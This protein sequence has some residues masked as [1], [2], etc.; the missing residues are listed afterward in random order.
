MTHEGVL[1]L[2]WTAVG[3]AFVHTIIG[4]DHSLP[5]VVLA[6]A[7][8]WSMR[9]LMGVVAL[10]GA[11]HVIGSIV[12]GAVG[13]SI[14]VALDKL[15][16]IQTARGDVAAWLL[17]GF[18]LAYFAWGVAR[19]LRG[20]KHS[21]W[22]GH[23]DGLEHDHN[24]DHHREHLHAH[25][26]TTHKV[27]RRLITTWTLFIIFAFGPCEALIPLLMAPAW[28]HSW[29]LVVAVALVFGVVTIGTMMGVVALAY[30]G[31]NSRIFAR[32]ELE[33]W[34]DAL[35]GLTIA[36]SGAAIMVLGI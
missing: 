22:H 6:K 19:R 32:L 13:I 3:I 10:C 11:G 27:H 36:G 23:F 8:R 14:G 1:V 24:H 4:V 31:I 20:H 28:A 34:A 35:A 18:G 12:L 30:R 15:E 26:A 9:K 29:G 16:W 17:I 21:H 2:L 7:Q 25:E 5:F 33:K